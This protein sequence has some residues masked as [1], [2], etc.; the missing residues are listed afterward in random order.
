MYNLPKPNQEEADN[1]KKL[2]TT[3][4]IE[5]VIKKLPANKIPGPD[6]FSGKFYQT[7]KEE[8]TLSF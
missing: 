3:S 5:A 8:L 1:L 7:F 6:G 4:K 2:I